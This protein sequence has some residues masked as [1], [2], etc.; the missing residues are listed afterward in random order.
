[1]SRY[2]SRLFVSF[3]FVAAGF[4]LLGASGVWAVDTETYTSVTTQYPSKFSNSLFD[5]YDN[6]VEYMDAVYFG[7][8]E[9]IFFTFESDKDS[10]RNKYLYFY[11]NTSP[12]YSGSVDIQ[13][14][15]TS[16]SDSNSLL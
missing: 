3:V 11:T 1:M 4:G 14:S 9:I 15:R 7:G 2:L 12:A 16:L 5:I 6:G 10:N 13:N 8:R